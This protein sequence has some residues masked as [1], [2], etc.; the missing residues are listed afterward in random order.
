MKRVAE[1]VEVRRFANV[2][3]LGLPFVNIAGARWNVVPER[4]LIRETAVETL[5]CFR[6]E[7]GAHQL[8]DLLHAGPD[9]AQVDLLTIVAGAERIIRHVDVDSSGER[10]R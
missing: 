2:S 5:I 3:R 4:V 9:V 1:T 8:V 6:I 7:R 10:K